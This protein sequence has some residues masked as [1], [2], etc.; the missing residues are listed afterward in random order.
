M[1]FHRGCGRCCCAIVVVWAVVFAGSSAQA[2]S[3]GWGSTG[4]I[5]LAGRDGSSPQPLL[6]VATTKEFLFDEPTGQWFWMEY[7]AIRRCN[8]DGSNVQT[9]VTDTLTSSNVDFD[10]DSA[11]GRIYWTNNAGQ[12]RRANFDGSGVFTVR[13]GP[14]GPYALAVDPANNRLFYSDY[15][16]SQT[17]IYRTDLVGNSPTIIG[18]LDS[19][20]LLADMDVDPVDQQVYW[21]GTSSFRSEVIE[22]HGYDYWPTATRLIDTELGVLRSLALDPNTATM[23]LSGTTGIHEANTD[24]SGLTTLY[25]GGA[26]TPYH[27]AI[28]SLDVPE[29]SAIAWLAL[30]GGVLSRRRGRRRPVPLVSPRRFDR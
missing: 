1:A 3:L 19:L 10:I 9:V 26:G 24:G 8:F 15:T 23:V 5:M 21:L 17:T 20:W 7:G 6:G 27:T 22:R 12:L 2:A 14:V 4:G 11:N 25:A 30:A 13:S 16:G 28:A 18:F 29:P